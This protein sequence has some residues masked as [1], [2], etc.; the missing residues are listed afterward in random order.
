M[1]SHAAHST[2]ARLT[3]AGSSSVEGRRHEGT[4]DERRPRDGVPHLAGA[5]RRHR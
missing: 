5:L 4:H 1:P 3:A 2:N